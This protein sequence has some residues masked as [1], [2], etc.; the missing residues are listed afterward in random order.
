MCTANFL[1]SLIPPNYIEA[2]KLQSMIGDEQSRLNDPIGR[3]MTQEEWDRHMRNNAESARNPNFLGIGSLTD[4]VQPTP[5]AEPQ[6]WLGQKAYNVAKAIPGIAGNVAEFVTLGAPLTVFLNTILGG[7]NAQQQVYS[8]Q[9]SQG[10]SIE[11]ARTIAEKPES[12][13][14]DFALRGATNAG[15]LM[16]FG[17]AYPGFQSGIS[18]IG[19]TLRNIGLAS[20]VSGVGAMGEQALTNYRSDIENDISA[21][22]NT[23]AEAAATTGITGLILAGLRGKQLWDAQK[24]YNQ[25]RGID[26]EFRDITPPDEPPAIL[27]S[28]IGFFGAP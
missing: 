22:G 15:T 7:H 2:D 4:Y 14:A 12:N 1:R 8:N 27:V 21:L 19:H 28:S 11:E 17:R 9:L 5:H 10:K 16:A 23:G 24:R 13:L 26:A 3:Y 18:P 20:G 25:Y 6:S